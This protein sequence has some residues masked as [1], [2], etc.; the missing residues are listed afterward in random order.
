MD[1]LRK[2]ASRPNAKSAPIARSRNACHRC[3]HDSNPRSE[4]GTHAARQ[5]TGRWRCGRSCPAHH[6][7]TPPLRW[8]S[9]RARF[10]SAGPE[11]LASPGRE[12]ACATLRPP[13]QSPGHAHA[14]PPPP[15]G[16][17]HALG[18]DSGPRSRQKTVH[19]IRRRSQP[20]SANARPEALQSDGC[21][22]NH[23]HANAGAPASPGAHPNAAL[24]VNPAR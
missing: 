18:P 13:A 19:A 6:R 16:G 1:R 22:A 24:A 7:A 4:S 17:V 15:R 5:A 9:P 20:R 2:A 11:P 8:T 21:A 23:W 12:I 3:A 10:G 14:N